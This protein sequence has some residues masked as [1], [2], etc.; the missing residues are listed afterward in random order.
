MVNL[1]H[2]SSTMFRKAQKAKTKK[3]ANRLR[4]IANSLRK[5][6]RSKKLIAKSTKLARESVQGNAAG[7]VGAQS[8]TLVMHHNA[9]GGWKEIGHDDGLISTEELERLR[10]KAQERTNEKV[11]GFGISVR[12]ALIGA[13]IFGR[14]QETVD[15]AKRLET[16]MEVQNINVVSA[17][18][19]E[20]NG[21]AA[22]NR[23]PLPPV[24]MVSGYTLARV[25]DALRRAGYTEN[26]KEGAKRY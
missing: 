12:A 14:K 7:S 3:E 13:R 24:I 15:H 8:Q 20:M 11:D 19:A 1:E 22:M 26:G 21:I 23:G 4:R 9:A 18:I 5:L 17:F 16:L 6:E 2:S 25:L 10:S